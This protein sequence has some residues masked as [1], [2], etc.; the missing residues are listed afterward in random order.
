MENC[1]PIPRHA[2][3]T[4]SQTF[5]Q[6]ARLEKQLKALEKMKSFSI[7]IGSIAKNKAHTYHLITLNSLEHTVS[8]KSYDRDSFDKATLDYNA[9]EKEAALGA[10]I[11]PVLVSAGPMETL[12]KAYPNLFLDISEFESTLLKIIGG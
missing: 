2:H 3:L 6:V 9:I 4:K 7:A 5:R 10:K 8:V 12:K 1:Q 11:E